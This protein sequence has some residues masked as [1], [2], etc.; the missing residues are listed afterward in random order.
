[1]VTLLD[2]RHMLVF[3]QNCLFQEVLDSFGIRNAWDGR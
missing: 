3:G 1:M 2:A